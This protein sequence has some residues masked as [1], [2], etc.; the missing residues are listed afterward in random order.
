VEVV[1]V[2]VVVVVTEAVILNNPW[3]VPLEGSDKG[4]IISMQLTD[5]D[6]ATVQAY[7]P[8]FGVGCLKT[9]FSS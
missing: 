5:P 1:G 7:K 9:A 3:V 8:S 6:P 4:V 2:V